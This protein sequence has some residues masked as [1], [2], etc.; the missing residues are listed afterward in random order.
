MIIFDV[1]H[2]NMEFYEIETE[3]FFKFLT[4]VETNER[5]KIKEQLVFLNNYLKTAGE[6]TILL[7]KFLILFLYVCGTRMIKTQLN[8]DKLKAKLY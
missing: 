7:P 4:V 1:S 5:M 2:I 8:A 6:K 3:F